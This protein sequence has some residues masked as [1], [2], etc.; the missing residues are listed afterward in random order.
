MGRQVRLTL[1]DDGAAPLSR[2]VYEQLRDQI[3]AGELPPGTRLPASRRLA[4][5]YALARVTVSAAYEQ[6][7]AEGYVAARVGAGTF[8]T[9]DLPQDTDQVGETY[10][11]ALSHWG[12]RVMVAGRPTPEPSPASRPAID[13]GFGRS[14]PH[15]FPYDI[16]RRLL[17]RYLSTDDTMLSRY[18]SS[19]GFNPLREAVA[20]YVGRL[21]GVRCTA[22]QVVIVSGMQQ[23]LD[24]LA[25]LLLNEE[26]EI[27]VETPGYRGAF[28][29]FRTF[30]ARLRPLAVDDEGFPVER[31]TH[32]SRARFAFV[33]PS[34]QFPRGGTMPLGRRLALLRWAQANDALVFEDD[35]DGELRYSSHPVAALQGLDQGG[36]VVYLGTFSK[37][38]FPALRLGYVVLPSALLPAF[39]RAKELVDRGA[40][41]LT[42]AAVADFIA[43]GHFERHLR[44]LR[45]EYGQRRRILALALQERLAGRVRFSAVEAGLHVMLLLAPGTDEERVVRESAAAGV[46]VY[47]GAP[48]HL[49]RPAEASILLGFSGLSED[50]IIVGVEKLAAVVRGQARRP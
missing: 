5:D 9:H 12:E 16:W 34:N 24:I 31:I 7:Q 38:L 36:R 46:G 37:V 15:I 41:T 18:G 44:R 10:S 43:E 23:A 42:Q 11:P 4:T 1:L 19:A 49:E 29:L 35:Y 32:D 30:G 17:A 40:P 8:V 45:R 13:F 28:D 33:T 26:D 14:F 22:Q 2:Q 27:L 3:L 21:R 48:Y 50:E 47:P 20:D 39:L 6:L 25:R